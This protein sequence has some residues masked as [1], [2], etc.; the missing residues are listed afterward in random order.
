MHKINLHNSLITIT[1]PNIS[2]IML[3]HDLPFIRGK[4]FVLLNAYVSAPILTKLKL[5]PD[6]IA[7]VRYFNTI[8]DCIDTFH[9]VFKINIKTNE[10][11]LVS[12]FRLFLQEP[13]ITKNYYQYR[14]SSCRSIDEI[15]II[16][17][18]LDIFGI[19][20]QRYDFLQNRQDLYFDSNFSNS[21]IRNELK[22]LIKDITINA[23]INVKR[24]DRIVER[25]VQLIW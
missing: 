23:D 25:A 9:F 3:D 4:N 5:S 7:K 16:S 17:K 1:G 14:V 18:V 13:I 24:C 10:M 19:T 11:I 20:S 22:R 12:R 2:R 21:Y 8:S 15:L 6:H